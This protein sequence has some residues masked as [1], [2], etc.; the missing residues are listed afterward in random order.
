VLDAQSMKQAANVI[1]MLSADGVQAANSG[2]P[3]LPMGMAD[4][5]LVLWTKFL[6]FDPQ[7]PE[8]PNRDRFVLSAGHGSMLLYT[9][10]HLSG[11]DVTLDDLRS[12]RQW[13]SRT[14]GHP[15]HGLLPG[16]ETT[17]GPLGQGFANGVGMALAA[18]MTAV[19]YD[20]GQDVLGTHFVYAIVSDGDL[21]EGVSAE[22]ASLAGHLGLGNIVYLY[23]S[24]KITIEGSTDLTFSEEV[25]KRFDAYGW[26]TLTVDGHDRAAVEAAIEAGRRET[27]RP[28]L[29][30][31]RT[32][33][34]FGSPK[35]QGTHEVHGAPLGKDEVKAAKRTLG[36]PDDKDFYVPEEVKQLFAAR[37]EEVKR[38]H[39]NWRARFAA[40]QKSNPELAQQW[41]AARAG[42]VDETV[43]AAVQAAA[44]T[45]AAATRAHS[46]K[47]I[48]KIA[49]LVPQ[50]V[51][52][53]ADLHPSTSTYMPA[54]PP[55]APGQ[56]EGRNFHFGIR[57][58]GMGS[59]LNG[60]ALYGGFIPFG[61]TFF[62]FTDYMRP[63]IRLASI[64]GLGVTYVF[65][66]DSIFVGEDGPTHQPVEHLAA[67]RAIP[68]IAVLRP[69]DGVETAFAW[70]TALARRKAPTALILTRQKLEPIA[71]PEPLTAEAFAR[72]GYV[73]SK[74]SG[75]KA[76]VVLVATGSEV[77]VAVAAAK[78]LAPELSVR[79]VSMPCRESFASQPD[80]VREAVVPRQARVAVI[81]AGIRQGWGDVFQQPLLFLGMNRFGA[82]APN[83]AL[84]EHFGF[85]G[86][87]VAASVRG[88][89]TTATT[90]NVEGKVT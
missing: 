63:P 10:L 64:M 34:G 75:D 5:A 58:H 29:I 44:P 85:T 51:G 81:E 84:A 22:A 42:V 76:D 16:V 55:I 73:V 1:R 12:F 13:G 41:E 66:H 80:A 32:T 18:K 24:N 88:W 36:L 62:V 11:Y 21:M 82:S 71:R 74:E 47:V 70:T 83:E 26:H 28:T 14:P 65:T 43:L 48:Q 54:Y 2:H 4:A 56:F 77:Q 60:L 53:S 57:E 15:E 35:K 7:D 38:E 37:V 9:M 89:L 79:V 50:F 40:W 33:I 67:L 52:G 49:E 8:W 27:A 46:G 17:T 23:D 86:D 68:E 6:R 69:A 45:G 90:W 31:T 39:Q 87:K 20:R 19:R 78:L 61:A 72:G 30:V 59:I 3:G 25:A